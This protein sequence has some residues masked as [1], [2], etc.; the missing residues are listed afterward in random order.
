MRYLWIIRHAK[1]SWTE[2]GQRDFDRGL[3][4]RGERNG[5]RMESYLASCEHPP[6]WLWCSSARRAVLTAAYVQRGFGID[7]DCVQ[8]LDA[9]YHADAWTLLDILQQT[10]D[11]VTSVALV[12]HNPG[13]TDLVNALA[14][15]QVTDNLPTFGVARLRFAAPDTDVDNGYRDLAFGAAQL[16][17][18][19]APKTIDPASGG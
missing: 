4:Q 10:P 9:L 8:T 13:L 19:F 3:N 15:N 1:S 12:A 17:A 5:A 2:A 11:E 18:L 14:G 16:E 7:P 6:T